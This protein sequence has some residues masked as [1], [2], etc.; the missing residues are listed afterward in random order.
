MPANLTPEYK[1]AQ[2]AYRAA[3]SPEDKLRCLEHMLSVIPKHKGTEKMQG[4]LK[5]KIAKF[6]NEGGKKGGGGGRR[7]SMFNVTRE[8]AGQVV[9]AGAP[10]SGKSA[11]MDNLTNASPQVADYPYTTI[12][13]QPGMMP[14]ENIKIQ[15]VDIPPLGKEFTESWIPG[16]V[17]NADMALLVANLA[18][19]EVL[20]ETQFVI[21]KLLE[22]KVELV[23]NVEQRFLP[24]GSA[25]VKTKMVCTHA[26][27]PDAEVVLEFI[28]EEFGS[29]FPLWTVDTD[30]P[31]Q[32]ASLSRNI[33]E[34]LEIIRVYTK[35]RGKKPEKNNPV[36]L[37]VGST[38]MNFAFDIHKDLARNLKYARI[39]GSEKYEGQ[40]VTKDYKLMDEDV[41]E[42]HD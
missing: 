26:K 12:K 2:R 19:D 34:G 39:W 29:L 33:F 23:E 8:G 10:N 6:S 22:G 40:K 16:I 32:M 27:T 1:E 13:P 28:K 21:D 35:S 5:K 25:R 38:V 17:R 37:P 41:V 9:L 14:Y 18:S 15:I 3:K 30:E 24:D 31:G 20:E 4:D 36:V 11:I 7:G 42:L